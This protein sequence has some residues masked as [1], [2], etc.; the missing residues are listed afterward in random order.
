MQRKRITNNSKGVKTL[1]DI[2]AEFNQAVI[3][4]II[5]GDF[6]IDDKGEVGTVYI[7]IIDD[8][9]MKVTIGN[10]DIKINFRRNELPIITEKDTIEKI[11]EALTQE[12]SK[13]LKFRIVNF[14]TIVGKVWN[15]KELLKGVEY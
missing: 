1:K 8:F 6:Q 5:S 7:L 13:R 14:S 11:K 10:D 15:L 4:K 12:D 9:K 3:D 2:E